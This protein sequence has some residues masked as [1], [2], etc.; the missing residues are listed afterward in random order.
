[1]AHDKFTDYRGE[2]EA[3]ADIEEGTT[4]VLKV[5]EAP[6]CAQYEAEFLEDLAGCPHTIDLLEP[7][8]PGSRL[9]LMPRG[10]HVYEAYT[11]GVEANIKAVFTR[12]I[13]ALAFL[14][15]HSIAHLDIKPCNMVC[16][17]GVLKLIDFGSARRFRVHDAAFTDQRL[18]TY[19]YASKEQLDDKYSAYNAYKA[20]VWSAGIVL[21]NMCQ[22]Y[23]G[24]C[25]MPWVW[26]KDTDNGYRFWK[27]G[28]VGD[29][30]D[31]RYAVFWDSVAR[32]PVLY[33]VV[34]MCLVEA[35]HLRSS[36][37]EIVSYCK[38]NF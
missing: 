34:K 24:R 11:P 33:D 20:D 32:F 28:C 30:C 35:S 16:I 15:E 18:T 4:V 12:L 1:M 6:L 25:R 3:E 22:P 5:F 29:E 37:A 26:A 10:T 23:D 38:D 27:R 2:L 31:K 19:G 21:A 9:L 7:Y 13:G 17:D 14:H 8:K 36:A